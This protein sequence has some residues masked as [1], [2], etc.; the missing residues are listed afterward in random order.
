M[1]CNSKA[2]APPDP[3]EL[4]KAQTGTNLTTSI[5]NT[6]MQNVDRV[7]ADGSTLKYNVTGYSPQYDAYTGVMNYVPQYEAVEKLSPTSQK[8]FDTTQGA[9]QNLA[10]AGK[11]MSGN[12]VNQYS[13]A[14]KPD[15]AAIEKR[16][17]DLG[18]STLDPQFQRQRGDLQTQLSNQGI[19]LGSAAYDRAL[20]E[21]GMTQ[22]Q[23]YNQLAL[24]GRG[25]AFNELQAIRNQPLNEM[26]ALLSGSQVS[27]PNYAVN[28]PAGMPTTDVAG[29]IND[30]YG[31]QFGAWQ[32][33]QQN[34]QSFLGGLMG[35]GSGIIMGG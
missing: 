29:L 13:Q 20:N 22:N 31:Q 11:N 35:L 33:N 16:L 32:T 1:C 19:K 24:Q 21:Q 5:A 18:R 34:K 4:A 3:K 7:G 14:W 30:N 8:I 23:A 12:L 10:T 15:T 17:F 9:K 25:Q 28:T 2:P 6:T 27:M 26:S